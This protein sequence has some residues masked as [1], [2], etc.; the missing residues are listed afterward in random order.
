[1]KAKFLSRKFLITLIVIGV[2][3]ALLKDGDLSAVLIAAISAYSL[4]NV[5]EYFYDKSNKE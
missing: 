3:T 5:G 4:G 1:M 2:S